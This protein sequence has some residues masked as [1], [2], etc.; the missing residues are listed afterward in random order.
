MK[1]QDGYSTVEYSYDDN[2]R[3]IRR[4][5]VNEAAG[6]RYVNEYSY[7][8]HDEP[9]LEQQKVFDTSGECIMTIN[10][11]YNY[12]TREDNGNWTSNS[13]SLTYWEKGSETQKTT[14]LQKR[15]LTYWE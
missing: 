4:T 8:D 6:I 7:N 15:T 11:R 1:E 9:L 13:L 10:M 5:L 2:Y 3:L 12:L 14:V